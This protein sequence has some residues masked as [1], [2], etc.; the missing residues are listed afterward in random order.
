MSRYKVAGFTLIELMIVL[1]IMALSLSLI[2]P[3]SMRQIDQAKERSERE[4]V[5][6]L[7]EKARRESYFNSISQHLTFTGKQ[8]VSNWPSETIHNLEF[9]AFSEARV[10]VQASGRSVHQQLS[11]SIGG[12]RWILDIKDE[13]SSW[14]NAD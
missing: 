13:T 12:K 5:V 4:L 14:S 8:V 10:Q 11:A 7:L 2:L 6:L 9:V 1:V 3:L